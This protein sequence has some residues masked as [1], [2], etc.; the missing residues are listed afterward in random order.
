VRS[1]VGGASIHAGRGR[2]G[3]AKVKRAWCCSADVGGQRGRARAR[4]QHDGVEPVRR[5]AH[6]DL[7]RAPAARVRRGDGDAVHLRAHDGV[8][9]GRDEQRP[10][11]VDVDHAARGV[12]QHRPGHR[13]GDGQAEVVR[14]V[15]QLVGRARRRHRPG[16]LRRVAARDHAPDRV[17]HPRSPPGEARQGPVGQPH[18]VGVDVREPEDPRRPGRPLRHHRRALEA[19]HLDAAAHEARRRRQPDDPAPDHRNPHSH[20]VSSPTLG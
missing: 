2:S 10:H 12:H 15:A 5:A 3:R 18:Q 19:R 11:G 14:V 20:E 8:P 16:P 13:T 7:R 6:P 9:G 1:P 17:D 4:G